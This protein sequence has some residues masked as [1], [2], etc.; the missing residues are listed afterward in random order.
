MGV[1]KND[2]GRP[3]NKTIMIRNIIK[4]VCL[5]IVIVLAFF[6]GYKYKDSNKV[7]DN[8]IN[9]KTNKENAVI[10]S[11]LLIK[12]DGKFDDDINEEAKF[13]LKDSEY[14]IKLEWR[15]NKSIIYLQDKKIYETNYMIQV[16]YNIGDL[17]MFDE[18][19]TDIID[20]KIT[21]IDFDGNLVKQIDKIDVG[22]LVFRVITDEDN[23]VVEN[24]NITFKGSALYHGPSL[25]FRKTDKHKNLDKEKYK[26][27]GVTDNIL[28]REIPIDEEARK[29]INVKYDDVVSCDFKISYLGDNKF[30]KITRSNEEKF[31][32]YVKQY[33][34][35]YKNY[36]GNWYLDKQS[37][38][39][40]NATTLSIKNSS[41]ENEIIISFYI[42]RQIEVNNIR[43]KLVN[44][45]GE[46]EAETDYGTTDGNEEKTYGTIE[47]SD[48]K[49]I[50]NI[51][52]TNVTHVELGKYT[53]EYNAGL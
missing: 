24:G 26:I 18:F 8:N 3:S 22:S 29:I 43:V 53:F 27:F 23:L 15:S 50:F 37:N 19:G 1:I 33:N 14:N 11:K 20:N 7:T 10:E 49:V 6:I 16:I 48:G 44:S 45:K 25:M 13:N 36:L 42:T 39:T 47:F 4:I 51:T 28:G 41:I 9:K 21:F 34:N 30:S 35:N 12:T 17:L 52:K 40:K 32:E 31:K 38:D 46:F 2:V 5:L